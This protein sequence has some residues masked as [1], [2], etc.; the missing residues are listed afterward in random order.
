MK[1]ELKDAV[2]VVTG[3]SSGIGRETALELAR[4]GARLVVA[5]RREAPLE[6]LQRECEAAGAR[7]VAVRT[8]VSQEEEVEALASRAVQEF[9]RIDGWVNDAGVYALGSLEDTPLEV[10]RRVM[11]VNYLGTVHGTRAAVRRMRKQ[12]GGGVIINISSEAASVSIADGAAY[13]ASKHAVRGFTSAIRQELLGSG[14][15]VCNV[16]PAGIDTPLFAHAANYTGK[17]AKAPAPVYPPEKVAH[18]ILR[19]LEHPQAEIYVGA[20]AP[21]FGALR[22][23]APAVFDRAM[24][25][26]SKG[27]YRQI[28]QPPTAG[29]LYRPIDRG[30]GVHGGQHGTAKQWA[31]RL[32]FLGALGVAAFQVTRMVEGA[33]A[34][35]RR[36]PRRE[37]SLTSRRW[38]GT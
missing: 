19:M 11:E 16:M 1:R 24:K 33:L 3:A 35:K 38:A 18:V 7:C 13:S 8:D 29:N 36:M 26:Q 12:E 30:Q 27:H 23:V 25:A 14:I 34:R 21:V 15:E 20:T 22:H 31:R 32:T 6:S 28:P 17:E 2:I 5:A 37:I 4:A 10:F 9:G